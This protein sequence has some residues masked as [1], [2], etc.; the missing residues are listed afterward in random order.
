MASM[1][2]I[3]LLTQ[4]AK[5]STLDDYSIQGTNIPYVDGTKVYILKH[6]ETNKLRKKEQNISFK[7]NDIQKKIHLVPKY[8]QLFRNLL[9][10]YDLINK[11]ISN[12]LAQI[13]DDYCSIIKLKDN[14]WGHIFGLLN[15]L[16]SVFD[17]IK[18]QS[19]LKKIYDDIII[20]IEKEFPY[21]NLYGALCQQLNSNNIA[22]IILP[23]I[24]PADAH[25]TP[26]KEL[27]KENPFYYTYLLKAGIHTIYEPNSCNFNKLEF[28]DKKGQKIL[29]KYQKH[30]C[31]YYNCESIDKMFESYQMGYGTE[32]IIKFEIT[33]TD[34]SSDDF[35]KDVYEW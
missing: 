5:P 14:N 3:T 24:N 22:D 15:Q 21:E 32:I 27:V 10:K 26:L 12:K 35:W 1:N 23:T 20:N 19:T 6:L 30:C 18:E 16:E 33:E 28:K 11:L 7:I 8:K 9:L 29:E 17:L 34:D 25:I 31:K 13:F 4:I 2:I